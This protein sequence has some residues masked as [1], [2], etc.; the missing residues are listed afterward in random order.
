MS[1]KEPEIIT[2]KPMD[3]G[4]YARPERGMAAADVIAIALSVLWLISVAVYFL[5]LSPAQETTRGS[6]VVAMLAVFLPIALIW[7]GATVVKT[8]RV[9]R[10]EASRLQSAIDGMRQAYVSQAQTSGMGVKPAVERKLDEIASATKQT[11][12]TVATFATSRPTT[13]EQTPS[14]PAL[15]KPD[16]VPDSQPVLALGT[17][18]VTSRPPLSVEDFIGALDFPEDENDIE[19]FRQ[20]RR[21][22]A[23]HKSAKLVRSSQDV[24]TLLSQDGIYMD[25]LTPDRSRPELWRAFA[26]GERG[27]SVAGIGGVHDRSSLALASGRMR[28]DAVFRDAVHH[29]LREFDKVFADFVDA[30]TDQDITKLADTRTARCFMLL[31]RVTGTFD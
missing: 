21:A 6:F 19:G 30:A 2:D 4:V 18:E 17:P 7:I 22:L 5:I 11:Q 8:A 25:D 15:T 27:P 24:L 9:M 3:L 28:S 26:N 13:P 1:D 16:A 12:N 23:D 10:E 31:G 20:L 14:H 29:F